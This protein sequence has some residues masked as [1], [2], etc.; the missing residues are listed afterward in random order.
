MIGLV[1]IGLICL[2]PRIANPVLE[3]VFRLVRSESVL[4][5][6]SWSGAIGLLAWHMPAWVL[7]GVATGMIA[8][9]FDV[10]GVNYADVVFATAAAW[11]IG[12][13]AVPVPG[14]IGVREG[15][16]VALVSLDPPIAMTVAVSARAIF[17]LIDLLGAAAFASR[18][19]WA[20]RSPR[21]PE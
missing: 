21:A 18:H 11:T 14:G 19:R 6:P 2:H 8:Q 5:L 3:F 16:F 12:F 15:V 10:G 20:V 17:V 9:L 1:A 13:V 4:R 7:I